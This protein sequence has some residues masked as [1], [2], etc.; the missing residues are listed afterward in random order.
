MS[1]VGP[2]R[3]RKMPRSAP[4]DV[5]GRAARRGRAD[6][7]PA[8]AGRRRAT[9]SCRCRGDV[10]G[11]SSARRAR[12]AR[13][14]A[15]RR[16]VTTATAAGLLER[17]DQELDALLARA[18]LGRDE[19][20]DGTLVRQRRDAVDGLSRDAHQLAAL[21]RRNRLVDCVRICW[22]RAGAPS[23][24]AQRS[25]PRAVARPGRCELPIASHR[26]A[27]PPRRLRRPGPRLSRARRS[28]AG[29]N[30]AGS[31]RIKRADEVESVGA[32]VERRASAQSWPRRG[33]SGPSSVGM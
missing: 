10:R 21:D 23:A 18:L 22:L 16:R 15:R 32:A 17:V 7:A 5:P 1:P 27:Q 14:G 6:A 29:R 24:D 8:L 3:S 28:H 19:A 20:L 25:R 4:G 31:W 11:R 9:V 12:S 30:S 13:R 26:P 33:G 2:T